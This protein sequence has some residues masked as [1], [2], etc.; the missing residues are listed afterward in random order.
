MIT[1]RKTSNSSCCRTERGSSHSRTNVGG[2]SC[3]RQR[4]MMTSVDASMNMGNSAP[5]IRHSKIAKR[6]HRS[7]LSKKHT[8][9]ALRKIN[10]YEV[11]EMKTLPDWA[12]RALKTFV[13][14]FLGVLIPALAI[15]LGNGFPEDIKT[16]WIW[17]A[18]VIA[19]ALS[20]A[21]SATWNYILERMKANEAIEESKDFGG[22]D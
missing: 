16:F 13:Q 22:T 6:R 8:Q 2:K 11:I 10:S 3:T 20:S 19:S 17:L 21:I 18:P 14:T 9:N 7:R 4:H 5:R 15:Y 12:I 1:S